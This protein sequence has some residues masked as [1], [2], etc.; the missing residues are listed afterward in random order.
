MRRL[1]VDP[2]GASSGAAVYRREPVYSTDILSDPIWDRYRHLLVPYGIRAVWARP[3]RSR[4]GTILGTFANYYPDVRSPSSTDIQLIESASHIVGIAIERHMNEGKLRRSEACLAE[5]QRL[6]LT[7]SFA[8]RVATD[9]ITWSEQLY[10]TFEF[11]RDVPVTLERI[12]TRVHPQDRSLWHDVLDRARWDGCDFEC[13]PRLQMPDQS[14]KYLHMV[15]HAIRDPEGCLE[16]IG[17]VQDITE[18]RL[19]EE[20]LGKVRSELAHVSRVMSL[21]VLTASIAHEVNQPLAGII[22][23]ANTCLRMLAIEPPSLD[24]A[25]E[26]VRRTIRDG[27]RASKVISRLRALFAGEQATAEPVDLNEAVREAIALSVSS[28]QRGRVVL[29][30]ELEDE[31]PFITGDRIQLQQV[32]LNLLLNA[33][34]AMSGVDDRPRELVINT[35][36]DEDDRVRLTVQ[37]TGVGLER[38]DVDRL[39]GGFYTTKAGGMGIGLS[40]S[41][42]IIENHGGRIWAAPNDGPGATFAF[43][44]PRR[45]EELPDAHGRG[46]AQERTVSD[47]ETTPVVFVVDD[48]VSVRESLEA[49]IRFAGWRVEAF[50]SAQEFLSRPPMECASCLVLDVSLPGL[51]GL[52]LQ[53]HVAVERMYMPIIFITGYGDVHM[54]VQAMKAGAVEF[55]A[56]P[57]S[58]DALLHAIRHAIDRSRA[59]LDH[60]AEMRALRDGYASLSRREREVMARVASGRLN[61]QI[62][63]E[64]GISEITV[65][66]HR[67]RVMRKMEA[68]SLADLVNMAARLQLAPAST[69]TIVQ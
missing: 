28:L 45:R 41:R 61:K 8:W 47:V 11:D 16:Y 67:G 58:G 14:V 20:A 24:G 18:R 25:R 43:D 51:S 59:V 39:F 64:L 7:G 19:S 22:T 62:A 55:L 33:I 29:H 48:D 46:A 12:D 56:K 68:D 3:L 15:A 66:A 52:D 35:E 1:P 30:L 57:F 26:T 69:D 4:E 6:S 54:T 37:D 65:K 50:A 36:A 23:N 42:S 21:G 10:R 17:A 27:E 2:T 40:V 53:K 60:E 9:E 34:E 49:L 63:A 32:I 38:Q 5:A 13:E 31:L 44:I